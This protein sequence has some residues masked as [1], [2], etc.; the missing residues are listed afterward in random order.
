MTNIISILIVSLLTSTNSAQH[1]W[2][3]EKD[4]NGIKVYSS[5][6]IQSDFKAIRVECTF[7][8]SYS[9]LISILT[10]VSKHKSWVFHSNGS[11]LIQRIS[12]YD[13]VYR[14]ETEMPWPMSNRDFVVRLRINTD[15]LPKFLTITG[16]SEPGLVPVSPKNVRVKNYK[17]SWRVSMASSNSIHIHYELELDPGGSIPGWIANMF[18]SKGPFETFS[19]L[20]KELKK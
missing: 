5:K 11:E 8:G 13:V 3:L 1:N 17:A 9:K 19:N 12:P 7:S 6:M 10:N 15:S 14:G 18:V 20:E 16:T 2:K 4:K